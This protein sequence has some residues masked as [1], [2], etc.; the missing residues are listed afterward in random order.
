[1]QRQ[2]VLMNGFSYRLLEEEIIRIGIVDDDG[3]DH[4]F[5]VEGRLVIL[6][7]NN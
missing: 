1:M 3:R 5:V 7:V 6:I 2:I 4:L